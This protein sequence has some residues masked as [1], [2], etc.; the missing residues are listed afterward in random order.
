M[1][2]YFYAPDG[3]Y[4]TTDVNF[5][6][7]TPDQ[8]A[9][10]L[11]YAG[12]PPEAVQPG[13]PVPIGSRVYSF[14]G[15]SFSASHPRSNL[16]TSKFTIYEEQTPAARAAYYAM[17]DS[18]NRPGLDVLY[19]TPGYVDT[20]LDSM[21]AHDVK[22][23]AYALGFVGICMLI[24]TASPFLTLMAV[25]NIA[26]SF[27]LALIIYRNVCGQKQALPLLAVGSAFVVIGI[28]V[29]DIFVFVD[30]FKQSTSNDITG[31]VAH[32]V[33]TAVK[34][35]LFTSVTSA[36][37]FASNALSQIPAV[38]DFGLLSAILVVANYIMVSTLMLSAL[39][40]WHIYIRSFEEACFSCL[41]AC[42][43]PMSDEGAKG[44]GAAGAGRVGVG[45][46][47]E[48][49]YEVPDDAEGDRD[50]AV[51]ANPV[52]QF[53][54][55]GDGAE[56]G[57]AAVVP[58]KGKITPMAELSGA[59]KKVGAKAVTYSWFQRFIAN[60]LTPVTGHKGRVG[61][62]LGLC[63]WIIITASTA[64]KIAADSSLPKFA[65]KGSNLERV[66]SLG[67]EYA[68]FSSTGGSYNLPDTKSATPAPSPSGPSPPGP[69]PSP[70]GPR[71]PLTPSPPAPPYV[72]PTSTTTRTTATRTKTTTT[73]TFTTR[74]GKV[75]TT[76]TRT[77]TTQ[78]QTSARVNCCGQNEDAFSAVDGTD[79][80][81]MPCPQDPS[82]CI[83]ESSF[84]AGT[85]ND[86]LWKCFL[87][88]TTITTQTTTTIP[89]T[90]TRPGKT[91][92]LTT[93]RLSTSTTNTLY[94]GAPTRPKGADCDVIVNQKQ[95]ELQ[96]DCKFVP[97]GGEYGDTAKCVDINATPPPRTVRT[98]LPQTFG[99]DRSTADPSTMECINAGSKGACERMSRCYYD[100]T[101]KVCLNFVSTTTTTTG[102]GNVVTETLPVPKN[103]P[104]A[105]P[106]TQQASTIPNMKGFILFGMQDPYSVQAP[107]PPPASA[108]TDD[109]LEN[110]DL[111]GSEAET[112]T[113][114][115]YNDDFNTPDASCST[116]WNQRGRTECKYQ[117]N[118]LLPLV[119]AQIEA[120]CFD[121]AA[122]EVVEPGQEGNCLSMEVAD[123]STYVNRGLKYGIRDCLPPSASS[124]TQHVVKFVGMNMFTTRI[125][126]STGFS[127]VQGKYDE[128]TAVMDELKLKYPLL[129][130]AV[131]V[132]SDVNDPLLTNAAVSG[133]SWGIATSLVLCAVAVA[134]VVM[135][136]A[137]WAIIILGIIINV[138]SVISI[139]VWAGWEIG[140]V[141]A[142]SLSVL[143]GTSVD[144]LLHLVE[145]YLNAG[146]PSKEELVAAQASGRRGLCGGVRGYWSDVWEALVTGHSL[147]VDR[148][149][150]RV[151]SALTS[152][153]VPII[154]SAFTTIGSVLVLTA[155]QI[156]PL[157]RFG[158][159]LATVSACSLFITM[160]LTPGLLVVFGPR[161]VPHS[162]MRFLSTI[163]V[164]AIAVGALFMLLF[165]VSLTGT[166][167]R[168]PN[169]EVLF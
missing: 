3:K 71:P 139:F 76:K 125:P 62:V 16:L 88:K 48:P 45:G 93:T 95:C 68:E 115:V 143:V 144:Y 130:G 96:G 140:A 20:V 94:T 30:M 147:P 110:Y 21:I 124:Q 120:F 67:Q 133:A 31:R 66:E 97:A 9:S 126:T 101:Y 74:P 162:W 137:S 112:V 54:I 15:T 83:N 23:C 64:P 2:R 56:D 103:E 58:N 37:S 29:D 128:I 35:T 100:A 146:A 158:S 131:F 152:I 57:A 109:G 38:H 84:S 116:G 108:D 12:S 113:V 151:V 50:A 127:Q 4:L 136:L 77:T 44:Y 73:T 104:G 53:Q 159:I 99:P 138:A 40:V 78:P 11:E 123:L 156:E 10:F 167:V 65:Q 161:S 39:V 122:S 80:E 70:P 165:I 19:T 119:A 55:N 43:Q 114:P 5:A 90:A 91:N 61:V 69:F 36:T 59:N 6:L 106:S 79:C 18:L 85:T 34:A 132:S 72:R 117:R 92:A 52:F 155:C 160:V 142:V 141:E 107:A 121:F 75:T 28:A 46:G 102:Q 25:C 169:G 153:G 87:S 150:L 1:L 163:A 49:E 17:L 41:P 129:Q 157:Q 111:S 8:I 81:C 154:W 60:V 24:H 27:P 105:Q 32:T 14:F 7:L 145:A 148:R 135:N 168:G 118:G 98:T 149:I 82:V 22:L 164:A 33:Q 42:L 47:A 63:I 134:L 86:C 26:F 13:F 89:T 166:E 51:M